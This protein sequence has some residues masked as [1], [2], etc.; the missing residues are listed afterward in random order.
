MSNSHFPHEEKE[1]RGAQRLA[2]V[3]IDKWNVLWLLLVT[4]QF[5]TSLLESLVCHKVFTP[6]LS[7]HVPIKHFDQVN[8][9]FTWFPFQIGRDSKL[10]CAT[11]ESGS[12]AWACIQDVGQTLS[13]LFKC[14]EEL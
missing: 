5:E 13:H 4:G 9:K 3:L 6:I 14:A 2:Q 1:F 7:K 12:F 8:L 11:S 10:M